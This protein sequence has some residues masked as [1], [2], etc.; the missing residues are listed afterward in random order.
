MF[1]STGTIHRNNTTTGA[2]LQKINDISTVNSQ[3]QALRKLKGSMHKEEL[4]SRPVH[5]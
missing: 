1:L 4:T 3:T 5:T 2:V